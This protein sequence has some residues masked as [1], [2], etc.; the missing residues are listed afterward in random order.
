MKARNLILSVVAS[1]GLAL[2]GHATMI[3]GSALQTVLDDITVGTNSGVNVQ[4]DQLVNDETWSISAAS[5][6]VATLIIELA[7]FADTTSFGIYDVSNPTNFVELMDG[8][9]GPGAQTLVNIMEDGQVR[10]N[11]ANTGT[12]FANNLFG[13]Y[14]DV[15]GQGARWHSETDLNV[16]GVDHM[17]AF[18]GNDSDV[19][20]LPGFAPGLWQSTE[21]ILAFEDLFNGGDRDYTDFVVMVASIV[22][23]PEPGSLALL[24]L[25]LAGIGIS[26]RRR[27]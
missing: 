25:A 12:F 11:F 24:A 16:D 1:L 13:F 18:A 5:G 3:S 2:Q 22:P 9:S 10:V 27:A 14:I 26:R 21:Y 8:P 15:P 17:V 6:S 4:T 23:V 19:V 7:G 20:Q